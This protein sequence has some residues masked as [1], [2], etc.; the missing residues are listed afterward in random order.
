MHKVF[1]G[2]SIF[3]IIK[4]NWRIFIL[5]ALGSN[6]PYVS[7]VDFNREY[8][9]VSSSSNYKL[10]Q[11]FSLRHA[12]SYKLKCEGLRGFPRKWSR[13]KFFQKKSFNN[14]YCNVLPWI[15]TQKNSNSVWRKTISSYQSILYWKTS[16]SRYHLSY[17][18]FQKFKSHVYLI[19]FS[20]PE[21]LSEV[22]FRKMQGYY[23]IL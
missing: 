9:N 16:T 4:S 22:I 10:A 8:R 12:C 18:C 2:C 3:I 21:N 15:V 23:R 1:H 13:A 19:E 5:I 17:S 14:F 7:S 6:F 20:C 11:I